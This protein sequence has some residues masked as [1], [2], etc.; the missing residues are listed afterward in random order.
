MAGYSVRK[1]TH[2]ETKVFFKLDYTVEEFCFLGSVLVSMATR[3][4]SRDDAP[5]LSVQLIAQP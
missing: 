1:W 5:L 2:R 4:S 3:A